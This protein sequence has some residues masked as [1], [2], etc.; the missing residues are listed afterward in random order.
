MRHFLVVAACTACTHPAPI[1]GVY[2]VSARNMAVGTTTCSDPGTPTGFSR[3]YRELATAADRPGEQGWLWCDSPTQCDPL[4]E[5]F[6]WFQADGD[7]WS[8][9][10]GTVQPGERPGA[11][12]C[13]LQLNTLEVHAHGSAV[14]VDLLYRDQIDYDVADCTAMRARAVLAATECG[15]VDRYDLVP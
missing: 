1:E 2:A 8:Q 13:D 4:Q 3:P 14:H 11:A 9:A 7:R 12:Y 5:D 15:A 10:F 6:A